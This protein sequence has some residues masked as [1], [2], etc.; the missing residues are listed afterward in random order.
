MTQTSLGVYP[1]HLIKEFCQI[2]FF[3]LSEHDAIIIFVAGFTN[4]S[5][6]V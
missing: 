6:I 2:T 4:L 1:D 5:S 3:F